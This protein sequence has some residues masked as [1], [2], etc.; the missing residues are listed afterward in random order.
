MK[1]T[2][3]RLRGAKKAK[4]GNLCAI[5]VGYGHHFVTFIINPVAIS[6]S[7]LGEATTEDETHQG[8][9]VDRAGGEGRGRT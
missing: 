8:Q 3:G 2:G 5:K 4:Q 9:W 6:T 7:V 1:S